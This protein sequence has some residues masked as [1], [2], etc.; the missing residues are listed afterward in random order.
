MEG[1]LPSPVL[2]CAYP[3]RRRKISSV[4]QTG[5]VSMDVTRFQPYGKNRY[6]Y[7][8]THGLSSSSHK[9]NYCGWKSLPLHFQ[10][11]SSQGTVHKSLCHQPMFTGCIVRSAVKF[12][13]D[14]AEL[15][16]QVKVATGAA[17]HDSKILL[18][19]EFPT[20]GLDSVSGDAEGGIE[21]N[22]SLEMVK[23]FCLKVF[24]MEQFS[25]TRIFFPD[26]NEMDLAK[27]TVFANTYFK[28][29]YLTNPSGL[30]DIG[31]GKKVQLLDRV[32]PTDEI[33]VVA[34]PYFNVNEML[35]VEDLYKDAAAES[36][37]PIIVF[38]GELDKIRS[39]YYPSFFYP[40]LAALS[41][42][43]LPR[44]ETTYY[45]HNFKGRFGGTLFRAYPESWQVLRNANGNYVC[46]HQQ[47]T[48]PSLKDVAL[49]ILPNA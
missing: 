35:A 4:N 15:M 6:F 17:L 3:L 18:E 38:N 39:G 37:R 21:M 27:M 7:M 23:D 2:I 1:I 43:F 49:K 40:K 42:N 14:Y 10:S 46:L 30:E 28:M 45:I 8:A 41:K 9:Y 29:D 13:S 36:N 26:I 33:F 11:T 32:K 12:P 5:Q 22:L 34:Y 20:A 19:I 31:L 24:K 25:R 48:M 44:F 47:D 16:D